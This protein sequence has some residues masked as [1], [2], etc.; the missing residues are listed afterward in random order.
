MTK[1]TYYATG[2]SSHGRRIFSNLG[3][4]SIDSEVDLFSCPE[5]LLREHIR[6]IHDLRKQK[7]ASLFIL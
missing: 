5:S 3:A 7:A 1:A 4:S 6:G 2:I